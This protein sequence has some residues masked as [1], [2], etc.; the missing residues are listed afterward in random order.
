MDDVVIDLVDRYGYFEVTVAI[1]IIIALAF[2]TLGFIVCILLLSWM[3][4]Y[5]RFDNEL[6]EFFLIKIEKPGH[7]ILVLSTRRILNFRTI[8]YTIVLSAMTLLTRSQKYN[9]TRFEKDVIYKR[10]KIVT[11]VLVGLALL[12]M[13]T[14]LLLIIAL[15]FFGNELQIT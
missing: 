3:V 10:A 13:V 7:R 5:I 2:I 6:K 14:G 15:I 1:N 8:L 12:F 4:K 9:Y 11:W